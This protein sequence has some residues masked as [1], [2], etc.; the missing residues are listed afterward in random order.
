MRKVFY[1]KSSYS[2][3]NQPVDLCRNSGFV[4]VQIRNNVFEQTLTLQDLPS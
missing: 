1:S 4:S 2:K 3:E